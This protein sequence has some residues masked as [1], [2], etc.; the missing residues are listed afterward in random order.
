MLVSRFA[1]GKP[2]GNF[3]YYSR[4][5]DDPN[6][7]VAHEHRRELRS[8]RAF[9][10]W[11]NHDDSRGINSLDMLETTNGRGW[12]KHYMFDFGSILGSGTVYAQRH[13]PGNE[14]M[15][16]QRPG[17]LTLATFGLYVRPWITIDYPRVPSSV[18]RLEAERFDPLTWKPE[19]P[20]P[21]FDNMRPDDAFWAARIV[22][23]FSD[24]AIRAVVE[25]AAYSDPA[26][27]DFMTKT[28]IARRD[29][30]VAA[31]INQVCPVVDAALS[32][33]GTLAFTNAAVDAKAATA[34]ER[35]ELRWFRF[36]NTTDQRT[37]VGEPMLVSSGSA[38]APDGLT[39]GDFV[40]VSVTA[41]HARQ[42]GWATPSTF[43]FRRGGSG[44][45][46]WSLVGVE[47][48]PGKP[49]E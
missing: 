42:P 19:Y 43:Y 15:F 26:A 14:Y 47:R 27:T 1:P 23:K 5:P 6:D 36:D 18:G 38:R 10:A 46:S 2:L 33:D 29:K 17:W 35:Y 39:V 45:A 30:V 3:R 31:W 13:R 32:A 21:A 25:K 8:A 28:I 4:R 11:L 12:I 16:E 9:G 40:G 24:E 48:G 44:A 34:P 37:P 22:S 20:N 49:P 7:L 41:A